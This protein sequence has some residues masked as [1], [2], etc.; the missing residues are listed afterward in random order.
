MVAYD[1]TIRNSN[2]Y[3]VQ[4]LYGE[5]GMAA[6]HIETQQLSSIQ[7]SHAM[8]NRLFSFDVTNERLFFFSFYLFL[9][10]SYRSFL[11]LIILREDIIVQEKIAELNIAN[12]VKIRNF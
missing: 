5:D 2:R 9:K 4:L 10:M 1:G 6:E 11:I 8:F 3:V 7:P 12:L